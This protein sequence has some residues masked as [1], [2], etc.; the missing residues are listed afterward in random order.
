MMIK[1]YSNH[2]FQQILLKISCKIRRYS[3]SLHF[4]VRSYHCNA[5]GNRTW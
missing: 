2:W 5:S 3:A 4:G 1:F